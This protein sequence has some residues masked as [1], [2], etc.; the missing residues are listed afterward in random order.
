C[1][2]ALTLQRELAS[3]A[4]EVRRAEGLNF[5]V[6]MGINSGE[7]VVGQIGE[8]LRVEYTAVGHT[9][10]LAQRMESIAE[11]AKAYLTDQTAELVSGY[12][13]LD[14]LGEFD[15]KGVSEPVR[16]HALA[17]AGGARSRLDISRARGF[18]KFVGR[19]DELSTLQAALEQARSGNGAVVGVVG[20]AGGGKGSMW[21]EFAA[22]CR[23]A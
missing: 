8:D 3:Y 12:L 19:G 4:I 20:G 16:V 9:V 10:G 23:S 13:D 14:D 18:T 6:R 22:R 2:A 1:W 7:V 11:P 17:G 21:P 5:S 15:I